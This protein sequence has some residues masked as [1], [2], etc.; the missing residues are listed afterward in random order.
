MHF[1][2]KQKNCFNNLVLDG[3]FELENC[4]KNKAL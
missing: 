3:T 2:Q 1:N 4:R